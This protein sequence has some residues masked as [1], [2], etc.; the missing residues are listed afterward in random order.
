MTPNIKGLVVCRTT[1]T[2]LVGDSIYAGHG[3]QRDISLGEID[4]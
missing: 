2:L 4:E 1:G 3:G